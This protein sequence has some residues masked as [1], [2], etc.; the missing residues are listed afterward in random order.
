MQSIYSAAKRS[1]Q[2][3]VCFAC[4]AQNFGEFVLDDLLDVRARVAQILTGVEVIGMLHKVLPDT[5]G[6]GKAQVGV[7]IDLANRH[8]GSLAEHMIILTKF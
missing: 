7:D 8:A 3:F 6:A 1:L 5:G 2:R 4:A